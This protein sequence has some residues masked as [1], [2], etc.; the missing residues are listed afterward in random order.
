MLLVFSLIAVLFQ[1]SL[2]DLKADRLVNAQIWIERANSALQTQN[3]YGPT[4]VNFS[5]IFHRVDYAGK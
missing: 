2:C 4:V 3:A 5:T 1:V